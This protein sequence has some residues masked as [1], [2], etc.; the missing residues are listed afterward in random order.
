LQNQNAEPSSSLVRVTDYALLLV[1]SLIWG[2]AFVAIR[3]LDTQLGFINL[4]LLRWLVAATGY[5]VL[6]PF[7][8][9]AKVKFAKA[10]LPRL[11]VIGFLNVA[12]YHLALNYGEIT[13]SAGL[14]GLLITL[15]PV[16]SVLLAA[17]FLR[18]KVG[19]RLVL[20]LALAMGGAAV[21][22]AGDLPAG[23]APWGPLAVVLAAL[24][25]A[26]FG[27]LSRPLVKKYGALHVAIWAGVV[28]TVMILPLISA[29]FVSDVSRLPLSGWE[30]LLY[31]SLLSTVAGYS[32]FYTLVGR[33]GVSRLMIQ[34]YLA[35]V[36]SVVGGVLLLGET[37][38]GY[39]L[40]GGGLMLLAVWLATMRRKRA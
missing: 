1:L 22:F 2:L 15:G 5:L 27:L 16:F 29:S 34:L 21:L 9:K 17:A 19:A 12:V 18:E 38:S 40:L 28:G 33:V 7:V 23:V 25:Y 11:L 24:S 13:V 8:G 10:D 6:L 39:T 32:M 36:V 3:E 31:L 35:P 37:V 26:M 14:A 20:A 30:A 4:T